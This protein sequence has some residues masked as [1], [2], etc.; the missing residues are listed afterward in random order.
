MRRTTSSIRVAA[1][2]DELVRGA[3][4]RAPVKAGDSLSGCGFERVV[5]A[6]APHLVKYLC[7]DDDWI[8]RAT[9][10]AGCRQRLLWR[11]ALVEALPD[12]LDHTVVGVADYRTP[13]GRAGLA[14]LMRDEGRWFVPAGGAPLADAQHLRFLDHMAELHAAFWGWRD[15][16]GLM[17]FSHTY[18]F[19]TPVTTALESMRGGA[20][21]VPPLIA[22]GWARF[23][24]AAPAA[25]GVLLG[26][27][28]DPSALLV[29]LART[30]STLIHSDWKLGNLGSH[31]DGRTILVDWDRV[32]E[33]PGCADLA[34]YLAVNCDRIAFPKE[35]AIEAYR[36]GLE[37]R[38]IETE[39]WW[40]RQLTLA[41]LGALLQL[42]WAKAS[43]DAAELAWW[44]AR[45]LAATRF[46]S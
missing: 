46:L 18:T 1:S 42:G 29:A 39:P 12:S 43:G 27:L 19:L 22:P 32:T 26:L 23:S 31:P 6:G 8:M 3:T 35:V 7:V 28:A 45:A 36:R 21:P 14:V 41:L 17:P 38:G 4:E 33:G 24:Q 40:D 11:S 25:A 16:I 20:D 9:G 15:D 13:R 2:V 10:D 37:V 44:E 5:V 30:P 34:W